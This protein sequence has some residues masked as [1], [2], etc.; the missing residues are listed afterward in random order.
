MATGYLS[1][2]KCWETT[3][4]AVSAAFTQDSGQISTIGGTTYYFVNLND[5]GVW[6]QAYYTL[7]SGAF[8]LGGTRPLPTNVYG[9]CTLTTDTLDGL[10]TANALVLCTA[11]A[12][13]L[14]TGFIFRAVAQ[15]LNHHFGESND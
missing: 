3:A 8:T 2:G 12:V 7:T 1:A 6:K 14:V 13:V 9:S 5:A 4:E 11:F 10:T 15:A